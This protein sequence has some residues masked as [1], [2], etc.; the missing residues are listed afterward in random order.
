MARTATVLLFLL[1]AA[2]LIGCSREGQVPRTIVSGKITL[3]GKPV[4]GAMVQF[5]PTGKAGE[6][7][8]ARTD[9]GGRYELMSAKGAAGVVPGD[10]KVVLSRMVGPDGK[11]LPPDVSPYSAGGKETMPRIYSSAEDTILI[12]VVPPAP[13]ASIDFP[14]TGQ[15]GAMTGAR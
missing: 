7:G 13:T 9:E 10:Y 5:V 14:L 6:A 3:R 1:G 12:T 11:D 4:T 8:S 15:A 2:A